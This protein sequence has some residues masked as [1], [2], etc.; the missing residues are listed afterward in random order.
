MFESLRDR[1]VIV[2]G[3]G[4]GPGM[5][6]EIP[7][8]F[9]RAGSHL[10]L[11]HLIDSSHDMQGF[12]DELR[13]L[14]AQVDLVH[15]DIAREETS[16]ALVDTALARHGRVDVLVNNA[17]IST[18]APLVDIS[19]EQWQRMLDVNL[20]GVFL[21]TRAVLPH[22]IA[23]GGGR[24]ISISSQVGQKGSEEHAHY[25]AAKAGV[26]AFSK[27][28]AREVGRHGITVNCVAPGPIQTR[29]MGEVTDDWR[30]GKLAELV[31]PRFGTPEE[32]VPSVLLL[33]SSPGG[34]LY[35]GQTLGPNSGDVML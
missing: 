27:S 30:A 22:M 3:A 9:A 20:T 7:L 5:G 15:G 14:G 18:P 16:A 23:A 29:L 2:T 21:P 17:G 10:I 28:V 26:I 11:N 13:A 24:V 8:A 32:V 6:R 1:V 4:S 35:T 12:A 33:A 31:I 34:D 19:L 25:A